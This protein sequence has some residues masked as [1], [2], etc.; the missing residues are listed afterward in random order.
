MGPLLFSPDGRLALCFQELQAEVRRIPLLESSPKDS[1]E[2]QLHWMD[3]V[4]PGDALPQRRPRLFDVAERKSLPVPDEL[5]ADSVSVRFVKWAEDSSAAWVRWDERGHQRIVLWRLDGAGG[6]PRAIVDERS[7]TFIDFSNKIDNYFLPGRGEVLWTSE[8]DGW[9]HLYRYDMHSGDLLGQLTHGPWLVR[10]VL[11]VDDATGRVWMLTHGMV[12]GEDPYFTHLALV[13]I[14]SGEVK[15][16]T[17]GAGT[18]SITF[19]P[20]GEFFVDRWS[21]ASTPDITEIRRSADGRL[22]ARLGQDDAQELFAAGF[23]PAEPFVAPGRDGQTPIWGLIL[24]PT[25]FDPTRE[26]PVIE[27]IYAG[28]HD[29]HVPK[30]F[31][32]QLTERRLA[33][34]GFIVVR[35]DGMGTNWRH[36]A[37]HDVCWQNLKDAGLP[38]RI[39]WMRAAAAKYPGMD[40][41]HVGIYGGSAGGQNALAALLLHGDFYQAAASDCG[42]HDNRVDKRWWNEA[43]MGRLGPHYAQNANVTFV[44]QMQGK[45]LLTVGEMDRNVDPASTLQVVDALIR[46]DKDFDFVMVPGAGHGVGESP[47]LERRRQDFFVR[48]LYGTEPRH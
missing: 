47:Y 39:A 23:Q 8:R 29:Q 22:V 12:E 36:K 27:A 19:S 11:R 20:T 26:Y 30:G 33:E 10:Q 41:E 43:W 48:A 24:R 44:E 9:N 40:L 21:N 37:F 46:A 5:F 4:K 15:R 13:D 18:H 16:L 25:D 35:I 42:C 28:P 34:L 31:A 17:E 14:D 7:E 45:L 32:L 3:Y 1:V 6:A 2:P 38:D